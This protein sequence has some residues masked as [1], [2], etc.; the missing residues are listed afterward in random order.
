MNKHENL[1]EATPE[2]KAFI[3]QQI[4][5]LE[6]Y[7]SHLGGLG[8]F[9]EK[10]VIQNSDQNFSEKYLIRLVITPGGERIEVRG[11]S[12]SIFEACIEARQKLLEVV[13]PVL[14]S[15]LPSAE[16]ET[17]VKFYSSGGQIH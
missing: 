17:L 13:Q 4:Q 6:P 16:R 2:V 7:M 11:F 1:H 9:V 15:L 3:S 10:K 5:E 8:I 14:N 12:E